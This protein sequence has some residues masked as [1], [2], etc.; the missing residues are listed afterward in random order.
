MLNQSEIKTLFTYANGSLY[1]KISPAK[2]VKVNTKAGTQM[3]DGY[4]CIRYR[5]IGYKAHRLIWIYHYEDL[6]YSTIDHLNG[7]RSDNRI[8]NLRNVTQKVNQQNRQFAKGYC[9]SKR[10]GQFQAQVER[11]GKKIW[12]GYYPSATLARDAYLQ[13]KGLC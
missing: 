1:W 8:E 4:V 6:K 13:E 3:T 10:A 12:L 5:G 7:N 2:N 11:N 9:W